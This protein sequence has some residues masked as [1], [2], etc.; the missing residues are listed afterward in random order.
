[1]KMKTKQ[2]MV[3]E[4]CH[5]TTQGWIKKGSLLVDVRERDEVEQL[6]YDVPNIV[7]IPL[8]EF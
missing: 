3:N 4:I 2:T 7:N 1:M 6:A 5:T 8:S